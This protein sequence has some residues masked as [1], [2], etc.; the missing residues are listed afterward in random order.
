MPKYEHAEYHYKFAGNDIR[1][2]RPGD[3]CPD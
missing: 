2:L 3:P 1:V